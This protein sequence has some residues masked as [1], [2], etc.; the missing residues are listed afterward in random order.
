MLWRYVDFSIFQDGGRRHLG[1]FK[2]QAFNGRTAQE[3]RNA[4]PCQI[5]SKSVKPRRRSDN[6]SIFQ[7]GG[8]R[9]LAFL[10]F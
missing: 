8:R 9:R 2:F 3:G 4:L 7:D 5:G 1:F 10:N 6:F